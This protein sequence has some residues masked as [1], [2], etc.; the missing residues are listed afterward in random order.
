MRPQ[1]GF[2]RNTTRGQVQPRRPHL[3]KLIRELA[4]AFAVRYEE[5]PSAKDLQALEY[6][7]VAN[8]LESVITNLPAFS[9]RKRLDDLAAPS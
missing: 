8:V 6:A 2:S 1:E 3:D 7:Q 4:E 5:P 9:Y